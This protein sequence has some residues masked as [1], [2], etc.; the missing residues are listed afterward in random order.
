MLQFG[1]NTAFTQLL[2]NQT[3]QIGNSL[4]ELKG[5]ELIEKK[6]S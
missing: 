3:S 1:N 4:I 5:G 6:C 2:N